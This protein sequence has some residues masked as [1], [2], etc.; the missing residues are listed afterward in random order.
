MPLR[1]SA[2]SH[3]GVGK[4]FGTRLF[5]RYVMVARKDVA[6][7]RRHPDRVHNGERGIEAA[8]RQG[9]HFIDGAFI[10]HRL[11]PLVASAIKPVPRWQKN[12]GR[13]RNSVGNPPFAA[14]LPCADRRAGGG[15]NFER[16]RNARF[17]ERIEASRS[18]GIGHTQSVKGFGNGQ[19]ADRS[20]YIVGDRR[21]GCD[22]PQQRVDVQPGAADQNGQ[23][24]SVMCSDDLC[25]CLGRPARRVTRLGPVNMAEQTV[26]DVAHLGG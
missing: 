5:L 10:E 1:I 4:R 19:G 13:E 26:R 18:G 17:V 12:D 2:G 15:N 20:T 23:R 14:R 6:D 8:H 7:D 16:A 24:A 11:Q 9:A 25:V 3:L 21:H 22:A